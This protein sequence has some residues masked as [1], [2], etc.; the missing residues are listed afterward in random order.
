[1]A[2]EMYRAA[3]VLD[4]WDQDL[5]GKVPLKAFTNKCV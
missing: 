1:V 5:D 4:L 3:K 2:D